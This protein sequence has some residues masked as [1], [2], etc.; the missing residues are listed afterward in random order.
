MSPLISRRA[1][2]G[3]F[4]LI[5]VL[6]AGGL[7]LLVGSAIVALT[8]SLVRGTITTSNTT[9]VNSW[10]SEGAELVTRIRDNNI[11]QL[12]ADAQGTPVWMDQ[13]TK[14]TYPYGWYYLKTNSNSFTLTVAN[15]SSPEVLSKTSDINNSITRFSDFADAKLVSDNLTAYRFVC[16]EAVGASPIED[17]SNFYCNHFTVKDSVNDGNSSVL[18]G[19]TDCPTIPANP[20]DVYCL[21]TK[22]SINANRLPS[23]SQLF[24]P[25][26]NALKINVLIAYD[27]QNAIHSNQMQT[28]LTN[29]R[30]LTSQ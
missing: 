25:P 28:L 12:H 22:T 20:G 1:K 19:I 8:N 21:M 4:T 14:V 29:Y 18:S 7:L 23:A 6:V 15:P 24:I 9:I 17:D 30:P 26:G 11:K 2:R 27:D 10:L 5:E 13:A 3:G 16:I